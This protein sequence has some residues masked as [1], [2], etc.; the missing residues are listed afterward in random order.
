MI[1]L[2]SKIFIKN[3]QELQSPAVRQAY[4]VL[5]GSV[6]IGLNLLLFA[7]K[8]LA[9]ILSGSIA[10]TADAVNNLSDAGSSLIT[11]IGFRMAGQKPDTDHPFGH[12]RI[13]Y[14]SGLFVSIAILLMAVELIKSSFSKILHPEEITCTPLIVIIL[15]VSVFVKIYMSVYNRRIGEKIDSAAMYATAADSLSDTLATTV[16][17]L[18]TLCARFFGL[19]IDGYC[20]IAV[21]LF[22]LTAG[23]KA[24]KETISPL[25]GQPPKKEFVEQIEQLVLSHQGIIGVHDLI[26]HDYGPGR[27]MISLHAE[28]PADCDILSMHDLIDNIEHDLRRELKCDAVIHMDPVCINDK[29]TVHMKELTTELIRQ[30]S[31]ELSIHDFRIIKGPTHTNLIFDL[32]IPFRFPYSDTQTTQMLQEKIQA[33]D[34]SYFAVIDVDHTCTL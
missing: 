31:P 13:E 22:I 12:G 30:I 14:L 2:L 28:V 3:R 5:C 24:A 29:E 11:L 10:I 20:G 8:C 34:P 21:G 1:T 25:L 17:L 23:I 16:V 9:G 7:G 33:Y 27:M 6:G 15:V 18:S 4:G 26:V 19:Q 32:V